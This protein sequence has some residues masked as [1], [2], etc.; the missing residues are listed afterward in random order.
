MDSIS[1]E[2]LRVELEEDGLNLENLSH[3]SNINLFQKMRELEWK[4][5]YST[6]MS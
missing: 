5:T 6:R 4:R 3:E 1:I 2:K